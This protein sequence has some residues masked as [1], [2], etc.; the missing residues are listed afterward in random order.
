[1]RVAGHGVSQLGG[2]LPPDPDGG[3]VDLLQAD[4][5]AGH[6]DDPVADVARELGAVAGTLELVEPSV[7]LQR[8]KGNVQYFCFFFALMKIKEKLKRNIVNT[9]LIM[10]MRSLWSRCSKS[11]RA[12]SRVSWEK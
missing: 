9:F 6:A 12:N 8:T 4:R 2:K 1:M 3:Q 11:A 5:L 10:Q 7:V